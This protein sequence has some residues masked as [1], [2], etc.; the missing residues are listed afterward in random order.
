VG[1]YALAG[2][3]S[4]DDVVDAASRAKVREYKQE[5]KEAAKVADKA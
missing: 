1:D 3:R 4:V 5:N 2:H